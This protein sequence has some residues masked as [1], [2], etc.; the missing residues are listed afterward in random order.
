MTKSC[1]DRFFNGWGIRKQLLLVAIIPVIVSVIILGFFTANSQIEQA[2]RALNN[3]GQVLIDYIDSV[4][5]L[6]LFSEN[7]K[8]IHKLVEK[9]LQDPDVVQII[10]RDKDHRILVNQIKNKD[11][12]KQESR[13]DHLRTFSSVV[14]AI[15]NAPLAYVSVTLDTRKISDLK[16]NIILNSLLAVFVGIFF[17]ALL[18]IRM[19]SSVTDPIIRLAKNVRQLSHGQ[20]GIRVNEST[21]GEIA[22]LEKG[23]NRLAETIESSQI[24]LKHKIEQATAELIVTVKELEKNNYQL[25]CARKYAIE[26]GREKMEFLAKMSHEIRTPVNVVIGFSKLI[27]TSH[28]ER[29]KLDHLATIYQSGNQLLALIDDILNISKLELGNVSLEEIDFNLR[30]CLENIVSMLAPIA[31]EKELIIVLLMHSNVP[32]LLKGDPTRI[33]QVITNLVNNAI[34]FTEKGSVI[35]EVSSHAETTAAIKLNLSIKDTGIGISQRDIPRLFNAFSQID[36]SIT[37][38]FGGTGLGLVI[39]KRIINM[40]EGDIFVTSQLGKG[41]EFCA[42]WWASKQNISSD[43]TKAPLLQGVEIILL[44]DHPIICRAIRNMLL[45]WEANVCIVKNI[46]L[47]LSKLQQSTLLTRVIVGLGFD[48]SSKEYIKSLYKKIRATFAA[49]LIFL[50]P[51][52]ITIHSSQLLA[53]ENFSMIEKPIRKHVLL[54]ELVEFNAQARTEFIS[55]EEIN[56]KFPSCKALVAEDHKY[57]MILMTSFLEKKN[58][59]VI[60][61]VN[62]EQAIELYKTENVDIIFMDIH[63]PKM[64]G[65]EA[66]KIIRNMDNS[67]NRV[68]IVVLTADVFIQEN[69]QLDPSLIEEILLKPVCSR[70]LWAVLERVNIGKRSHPATPLSQSAGHVAAY[71]AV[72]NEFPEILQAKFA[73][74]VDLLYDL[75]NVSY[76][77]DDLMELKNLLHKMAGMAGPFGINELSTICNEFVRHLEKHD[78]PKMESSFERLTQFK[79]S[80]LKH[81]SIKTKAGKLN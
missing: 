9:T 6:G 48:S 67:I 63:M 64:D 77:Q 47:L 26:A 73:K 45:D 66:I 19:S 24:Q 62:G 14:K 17:S 27:E 51:N 18:A 28:N 46:D 50:I 71:A 52:R 79:I 21:S 81:S 22:E 12:L 39:A 29:E 1:I 15:P 70:N 58:V 49:K 54:T 78:I 53:D 80:L 76:Q 7:I 13:R 5:E 3:K 25:D 35:I 20:Y 16:T 57:N 61:A 65:I 75:I 43:E 37:R 38:R 2:K 11:R 34:K 23:F 74:E 8:Q 33:S 55:D 40:M 59:T 60:Q 32:E 69:E 68:P 42:E 30:D 72:A 10:V 41:S 31:Q 36:S 44:E 56:N 4:V